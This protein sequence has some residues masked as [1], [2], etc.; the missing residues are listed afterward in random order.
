MFTGRFVGAAEALAIGL[1]SRVT[2]GPV[3]E[4]AME[5]ARK[6]TEMPPLAVHFAKRAV[7][8]GMEVTTEAGMEV[9]RLSAAM[10]VDSE[11]RREGFR[12]FV[13]KRKP[14]YTGR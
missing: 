13:E 14:V 11:D 8:A 6:I 12:A 4:A 2:G 5:T 1:V 7:N 3:L 9:E 10:V